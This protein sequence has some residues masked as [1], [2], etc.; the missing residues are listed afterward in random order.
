MCIVSVRISFSDHIHRILTHTHTQPLGV[1]RISLDT[2][3]AKG[4]ESDIW[5]KVE[6]EGRM[7]AVS[8]EVRVKC[9][10][11]SPPTDRDIDVDLETGKL[12]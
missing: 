5:Y 4:Q 1:V 7:K 9:R 8:G 2:I 12:V 3:D 10:F 6:G 11:S